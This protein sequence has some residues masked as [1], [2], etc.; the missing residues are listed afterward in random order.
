MSSLE[1]LKVL[2]VPDMA[3]MGIP[4]H[5]YHPRTRPYYL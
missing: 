5:Y 4:D 3:L 2:C 1:R